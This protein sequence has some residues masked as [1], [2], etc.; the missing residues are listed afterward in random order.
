MEGWQKI[1]VISKVIAAV[2]IPLAVAYLGN[3]VATVNK[4]REGW[5]FSECQGLRIAV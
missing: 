1:E 2:L 3:Q 5:L 4:Q